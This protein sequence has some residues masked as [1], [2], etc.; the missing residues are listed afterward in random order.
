MVNPG[1]ASINVVIADK[2]KLLNRLDQKV[3]GQDRGAPNSPGADDVPPAK[4]RDLNHT[5]TALAK[6]GK[7]VVSPSGKASRK[8]S[9]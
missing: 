3:R 4:R 1:E 8:A 5:A 7:P 2:R 6:R 9:R